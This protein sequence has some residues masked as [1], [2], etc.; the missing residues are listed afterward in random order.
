MLINHGEIGKYDGASGN[1]LKLIDF[2]GPGPIFFWYAQGRVTYLPVPE[3]SSLVL[4]I[5]GAT[6]LAVRRRIR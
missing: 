3:P 6:L 1:L 5:A 2:A 4:A